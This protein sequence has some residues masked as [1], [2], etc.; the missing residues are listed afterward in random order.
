[1]SND[2]Y[3]RIIKQFGKGDTYYIESNSV[4]VA[5]YATDDF[6]HAQTLCDEFNDAYNRG[7]LKELKARREA[8]TDDIMLLTGLIE[9]ITG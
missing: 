5:I 7:R 4:D 2:Y 6:D 1:M 9:E 3:V 8:A